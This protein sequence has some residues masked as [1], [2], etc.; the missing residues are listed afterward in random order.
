MGH[1]VGKPGGLLLVPA[2]RSG[3]C[4]HPRVCGFGFLWRPTD[5]S[6]RQRGWMANQDLWANSIRHP[7][8]CFGM[9][10]LAMSRWCHDGRRERPFAV[11]IH[12]AMWTRGRGRGSIVTR[13]H[14][15][16]LG[17]PSRARARPGGFAIV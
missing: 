8:I 10:H 5:G 16:S 6:R 13:V 14:G 1:G 11:N 9:L 7:A 2:I 12:H 4:T 17:A 3:L 15:I